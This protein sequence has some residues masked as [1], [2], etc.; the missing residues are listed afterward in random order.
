[1]KVIGCF[2]IVDEVDY[3][4]CFFMIEVLCDIYECLS[5]VIIFI[6]EEVMLIKFMQWECVYG[7][8]FDWVCVFLCDL[9]DCK[10]I[11]FFYCSGIKVLEDVY[12]IL[13]DVIG[14]FVCW[15]VVE[16]VK[17]VCYVNLYQFFEIMVQICLEIEFLMGMLFRLQK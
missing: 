4:V 14:G 2:F 11:G 5:G 3:L 1:M 6:G 8:I 16:F 13:L 15:I 17:F 10:E 7:C 9:V 12:L